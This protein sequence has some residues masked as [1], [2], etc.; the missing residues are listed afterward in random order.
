[1]G[2]KKI[3]ESN[4]DKSRAY[5]LRKEESGRFIRLFIPSEIDAELNLKGNPK[6]LIVL[7]LQTKKLK[8]EMKENLF[9]FLSAVLYSL[10]ILSKNRQEN[11]Q[12]L[13]IDILYHYFDQVRQWI[14]ICRDSRIMENSELRSKIELHVKHYNRLLTDLKPT[15]DP[16]LYITLASQIDRIRGAINL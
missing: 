11:I 4:S 7:A 10:S 16:E 12:S 1:M 3:H 15:L 6:R 14:Q 2:R 5:R 9:Y 8:K 13:T